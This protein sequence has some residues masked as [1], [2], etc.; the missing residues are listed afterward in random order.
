[1]LD[2][3]SRS[4]HRKSPVTS[5][6]VA[7]QT[8]ATTDPLTKQIERFCDQ[9]KDPKRNSLRHKE[10]ADS[11]AQTPCGSP[12]ANLTLFSRRCVHEQQNFK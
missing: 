6:E 4:G 11:Q 1:M 3:D 10:K 12:V 8:K 2:G 7:R 9:I 5:E